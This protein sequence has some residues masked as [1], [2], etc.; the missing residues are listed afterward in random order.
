MA[1]V[2]INQ[3][4]KR[5][6]Y[7]KKEL[8]ETGD[9]HLKSGS[10]FLFITGGLIL[11]PLSDTDNVLNADTALNIMV[12]VAKIIWLVK[13]NMVGD[14]ISKLGQVPHVLITFLSQFYHDRVHPENSPLSCSQIR[15]SCKFCAHRLRVL[16]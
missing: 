4:R 8:S 3:I 10:F 1:F 16:T 13:S 15:I 11:M 2:L 9:K 6:N 14:L 5:I 12:H 7:T